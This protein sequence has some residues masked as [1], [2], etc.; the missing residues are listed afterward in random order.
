MPKFVLPGLIVV[1]A[2]ALLAL[3]TFGV[4][5]NSDA[6]SIDARVAHGSFP[7]PPDYTTPLPMLD[8][9][10]H[11]DLA[12]LKGKVVVLNMFA[13]WCDACHA[14]AKMLVDEQKLLAKHDATVLGVTWNDN[15]SATTQFDRQYGIR[16]PV[17][18]D[19]TGNFVHAFGTR[20]LPETFIINRQG[21]IQALRRFQ[22][23]QTWLDKT[24]TPILREKS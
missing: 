5:H 12:S 1:A 3:L 8:S 18:R 10:K 17:V 22:L 23:S 9:S 19:V 14:E 21:K 4:S 2:A 16:Y 15:S 11:L 6:R 7:T 13:S 24:L 20:Q